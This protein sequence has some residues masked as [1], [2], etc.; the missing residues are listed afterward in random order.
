MKL[1]E[2]ERERFAEVFIKK[3]AQ[4][5]SQIASQR[6]FKDPEELESVAYAALGQALASYDGV[7]DPNAVWTYAAATIR[8]ACIDA[9][10]KEQTQ[11][12]IRKG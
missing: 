2:L 6:K 3:T 12:E 7:V 4:L 8:N 9:I 5:S 1:T 10:R 11:N